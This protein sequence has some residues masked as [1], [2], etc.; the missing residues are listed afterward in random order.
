MMSVYPTRQ[1]AVIANSRGENWKRCS[2]LGGLNHRNNAHE[3]LQ[4]CREWRIST[5][6][7]ASQKIV[8]RGDKVFTTCLE[9]AP[10]PSSSRASAGEGTHDA[11]AALN[12]HIAILC[13]IW[14]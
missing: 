10:P 8:K 13:S 3:V 7:T 14:L 4:P 6:T 9:T 12:R 1:E 2:T 11:L 5:T